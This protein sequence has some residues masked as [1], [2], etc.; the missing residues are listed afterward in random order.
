M[1]EAPGVRTPQRLHRAVRPD[2][3]PLAGGS[4]VRL[5]WLLAEA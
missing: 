5:D 1:C 3:D 2:L 4:A